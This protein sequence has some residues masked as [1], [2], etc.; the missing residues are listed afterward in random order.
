[1][2]RPTN[3]GICEAYPSGATK[4]HHHCAL[5]HLPDPDLHHSHYIE[6]KVIGIG[7]LIGVINAESR[8]VSSY[9]CE[10]RMKEPVLDDSSIADDAV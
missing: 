8:K 9:W 4:A 3:E 1:M 10:T 7:C 2:F 6:E 5:E